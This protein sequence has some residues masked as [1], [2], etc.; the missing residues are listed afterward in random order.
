[1]AGEM[2]RLEFMA[3]TLDVDHW[4]PEW[5]EA[6]EEYGGSWHDW[7]FAALEKAMREAGQR[8]IDEH[9]DLFACELT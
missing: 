5:R 6:S 1:M 2:R 8:F 4:R 3:T 7:A 9:P